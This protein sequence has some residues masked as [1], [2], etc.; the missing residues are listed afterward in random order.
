VSADHLLPLLS[1]AE[2]RAGDAAA[3]VAG[4]GP[5]ALMAR[6]AGHLARTV[7]EVGGHA[8]G[9]RVDVVVGRGDNGGD[10]WAAAA[11]LADRGALVR[12]IAP[13][14]ID[15]PTS[16]A[17]AA[18]RAAWLDRGGRVVVG[19]GPD[20][21]RTGASAGADAGSGRAADGTPRAAADV[22]VDA[23]LG[24]GATGPLRGGAADGARAIHAARD[25]GAR[26]VA[27]DVP[28]GVSADDG[29][30]AEGAV[31]ADATVTFGALKRGLL[32]SP[33]SMHAGVLSVGRLGP[34][35]ALPDVRA[36][37]TWW[38]L[39]AEGARPD[40]L[41]PDTE[42]RRRGTVLIVAGRR[43][44]AGAAAL[45]GM[46]ALAGGAGLVTV[47]VPEGVRAE[48]A[49][50]H[51]ALM[52]VGLPEDPDGAVHADAVHALPLAG[53]DAVVAGPG[54]GTGVGA[55][56]VVAHLR[57]SVARLVLD[58]DALN[59]HRAAPERLAD[60][61][62][63]LVLTPHVRELERL[64]GED[65]WIDRARRVPA[66]ATSWRAWI[67]AKGPGTLVAA[68]DGQV[69]VAPV[70]APA[71]ATAGSGD[72]LAG[73]LGAALAGTGAAASAAEVDVHALSVRLARAVWWHA[74]A[75]A[76]AG[77]RTAGRTDALQLVLTVPD[78]LALLARRSPMRDPGPRGRVALEEVMA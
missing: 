20:V 62:G 54:L 37:G 68:P 4:D 39:S 24:T 5:A 30:A 42:K 48:V 75:G 66:L 13:D 35:Y 65:A 7:L 1:A 71:L 14:G 8:H 33:G 56:A 49:A 19:A 17:S 63:V 31:R 67:V 12:V 6:A 34:C 55:A 53:I 26:V 3:I 45:A 47:A 15:T 29:T 9:L 50:Q 60:H 16:D 77:A 64:A 18:A 51:P 57:A 11:L 72:V 78:A 22:V 74:A 61:A 10:G 46:G 58:A 76:L 28:S 52:V 36:P 40:A 32:L 2:A 69:A 21:L 43:G 59:V 23:L 38:A 41:E 25:A 27:C 73:M 70:A 44:A